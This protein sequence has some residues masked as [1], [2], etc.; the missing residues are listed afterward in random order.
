MP[1]FCDV[2]L[3]VPLDRVF[4]YSLAVTDPAEGEEPVT[5]Q[6]G[7]RVVVPFRNEKLIGVVTRVHD[8]APPVEAK[9]LQKVLD[10]EP[11]LSPHLLELATWISQYYLAPLGEVLRTMLPLMA[12]VRRHVLYRITDSGREILYQGAQLGSSR[13]SRLDPEQQDVEYNV[14]DYLES[15]ETARANTLRTATGATKELLT[16]MLRKKWIARETVAHSRDARRLTRFA[17][18]VPDTRLP[19]LNANQQL[20]LAELAGAGNELP[21]SAI[22]QLPVPSSTLET[23]V[24]RGLVRIEERPTD[25]LMTGLQSRAPG[26]H[27]L[28]PAQQ[29]ALQAIT[30]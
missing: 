24:R 9:P 4:T 5:P 29:E 19:K 10:A 3:P 17:C 22:R 13:R 26:E 25:F 1:A 2:A 16:G 15:G 8:E 18:L 21:V 30:S 11:L 7:C 23:L 28:N 20:I 14:L 12:E 6:I 27:D